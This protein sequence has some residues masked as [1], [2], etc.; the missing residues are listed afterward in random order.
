M[1]IFNKK[2]SKNELLEKIGNISQ[3]GGIK[4]MEYIDGPG[5]WMDYG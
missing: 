1:K 4:L 3:L 2:Y 5:R